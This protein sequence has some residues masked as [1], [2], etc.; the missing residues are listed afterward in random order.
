MIM[1]SSMELAAGPLSRPLVRAVIFAGG[2]GSRL[3]P[4]TRIVPKPL[5]PVGGRPVLELL[6]GH[7]RDAGVEEVILALHYGADSVRQMFPEGSNLGLRIEHVEEP[8]PLGTMGALTL[9]RDRLAEPFF[10]VNG[11]LVTKCDFRD[12]WDF[13]H[14]PNGT[15]WGTPLTVG[16]VRHRMELPFAEL[17]LT[18][19]RVTALQEKP[20]KE[21]F[22]NAGIYVVD[23]S[24][25]DLIPHR[26]PFDAT[27]LIKLLIARQ[28]PVQ[29]YY[30]K[31]Y[32]LDVGRRA[33]LEKAD[34]DVSAGLF[35]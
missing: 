24:A 16:M 22:V 26:R 3:Q 20:A 12:M 30:I 29:A 19:E 9:M 25:I 27:D 17:T 2:Q 1:D 4:L 10:V 15:P 34:L 32:W 23:P 8:K 21:Y 6:L 7:L 35:G 11:D 33:D 13:H 5:L 28:K 31:D 14:R 18:G